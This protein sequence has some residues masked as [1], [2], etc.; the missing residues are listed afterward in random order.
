VLER[1]PLEN[2]RDS[3]SIRYSMVNGRLFDARTMD[4]IGNH[5]RKRQPFFFEV[6]GHGPVKAAREFCGCGTHRSRH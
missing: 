4:E 6:E 5:P 1:N 2:I 3:E